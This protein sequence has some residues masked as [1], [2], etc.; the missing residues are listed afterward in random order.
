M[1]NLANVNSVFVTLHKDC[2][3]IIIN[4]LNSFYC[5]VK[6]STVPIVDDIEI[7]QFNQFFKAPNP[8]R[9]I[10]T[11]RDTSRLCKI[12]IV[13]EDCFADFFCCYPSRFF[14]LYYH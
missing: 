4:Q 1:R 14:R 10:K 12:I 5:F 7:V 8:N 13:L 3:D 11:R 9:A 6:S 2:K